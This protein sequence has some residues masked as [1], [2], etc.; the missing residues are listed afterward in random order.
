[1]IRN[2]QAYMLET[3]Q[4]VIWVYYVP[5]SIG[6]Y[7]DLLKVTDSISLSFAPLQVS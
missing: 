4:H 3:N 5:Y 1:M 7:P 2:T 6:A